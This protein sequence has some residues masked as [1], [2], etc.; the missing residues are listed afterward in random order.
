M[1]VVAP[2]AARPSHV[3]TCLDATPVIRI[4]YI[5]FRTVQNE[6]KWFHSVL[7]QPAQQSPL[8]FHNHTKLLRLHSSLKRTTLEHIQPQAHIL[9]PKSTLFRNLTA[10]YS[11]TM[12]TTPPRLPKP[13]RVAVLYQ[14]AP[15]PAV[16]GIRKPMK[17]GGQSPF[18]HIYNPRL[19]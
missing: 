4:L 14:A 12:S 1:G 19:D 3:Y 13:T 8:Q 17:P 6:R 5:V 7:A 9:M 15:P 18:S 2:N 11:R 16:D 10:L